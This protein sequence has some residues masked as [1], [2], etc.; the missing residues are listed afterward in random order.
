MTDDKM[1]VLKKRAEQLSVS[2]SEKTEVKNS[3]IKILEFL[4]AS[5]EQSL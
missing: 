4:N 2:L 5:I 3:T 1:H